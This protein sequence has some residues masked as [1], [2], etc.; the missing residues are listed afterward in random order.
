MESLFFFFLYSSELEEDEDDE[1]IQKMQPHRFCTVVEWDAQPLTTRML[2]INSALSFLKKDCGSTAL[3][4]KLG[5]EA[6]SDYTLER[7]YI[8]P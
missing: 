8:K 5:E 1:D 3:S 6:S 2:L 4:F 7:Y